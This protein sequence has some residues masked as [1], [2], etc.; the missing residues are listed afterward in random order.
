MV[1]ASWGLNVIRTVWLGLSFLVILAGAAS[2][3]LAFGHF[4]AANASSIARSDDERIVVTDTKSNPSR[5]AQISSAVP[6]SGNIDQAQVELVPSMGIVPSAGQARREPVSKVL[7]AGNER[8][9]RKPGRSRAVAYKSQAAEEA[10]PCQLAD[11][12]A[13]RWALSLPTGC[14]I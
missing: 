7:K 12:D 5:A 11:F 4:D 2:F 9:K 6:K 14:H 1:S 3:R 8:S 10:K 13:L